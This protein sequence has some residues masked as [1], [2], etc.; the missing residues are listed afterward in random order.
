MAAFEIHNKEA[1]R[2]LVTVGISLHQTWLHRGLPLRWRVLCGSW[3]ADE[4]VAANF[5]GVNKVGSLSPF[6]LPGVAGSPH[7]WALR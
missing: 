5:G 1:R 4:L 3:R 7:G 6:P 2:G